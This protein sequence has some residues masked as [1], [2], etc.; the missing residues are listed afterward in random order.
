[1]GKLHGKVAL[2]TGGARGQGQAHAVKLAEEGA[3]V[4]ICDIAEQISSV[5]YP[6]ASQDDL[7]ATV[8]LV[9]ETGQRCLAL[10]ADARDTT[11]MEDA[12]ARAVQQFGRIDI[13][14][15]NHGIGTPA[16][17]DAPE[18][19]I[20]DILDT[21]LKGALFAC[22]AVI[23]QIIKQGDGG[24]IVLT[25]S[26]GG[27]V[28]YYGLTVYCMAKHGVVGLARCL[29]AELAPHRIRVNAVCPGGVDSPML[30]ND[31]M[32]SMFSGVQTGGT[33]ETADFAGRSM[34]L[35][36]QAFMEPRDVANAVAWLVSDDARFVTGIALPVDMGTVNQPPGIPPI[37]TAALAAS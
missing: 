22:R 15:I 5:P 27:L 1:M 28:P 12:V 4:V 24:S 34:N 26:V 11:Q 20:V 36:P 13:A 7:D 25:S 19:T 18:E 14:V 37:A 17:W 33:K 10:K 29:S 21:N 6:M 9:E 32:L 16:G 31:T 30:D 2:I 8:K 23:P 35:L 3:Q